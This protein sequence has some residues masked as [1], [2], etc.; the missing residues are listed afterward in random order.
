MKTNR[1]P[2]CTLHPGIARALLSHPI[3]HSYESLCAIQYAAREPV[4]CPLLRPEVHVPVPFESVTDGWIP[5]PKKA[6]WTN[7]LEG[8]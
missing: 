8:E 1:H 5:W 7:K 3:I 4:C 6:S 2:H